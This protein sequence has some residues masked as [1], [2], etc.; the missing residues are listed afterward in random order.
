MILFY[1]ATINRLQGL[2]VENVSQYVFSDV[3]VP[4]IIT[5]V[6]NKVVMCNSFTHEFLNVDKVDIIGKDISQYLEASE[7]D[8]YFVKSSN[9]KA[10]KGSLKE[11]IL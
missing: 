5:D 11:A 2:S 1:V 9:A 10:G 6:D 7:D 4:V 8:S 3:R